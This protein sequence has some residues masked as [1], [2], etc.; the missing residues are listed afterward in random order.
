VKSVRVRTVKWTLSVVTGGSRRNYLTNSGGDVESWFLSTAVDAVKRS[1]DL[2]IA[3]PSPTE[4]VLVGS[5][6]GGTGMYCW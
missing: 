4:K 5:R 1:G 6:D 2:R 3:L